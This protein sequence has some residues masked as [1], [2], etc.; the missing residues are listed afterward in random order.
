VAWGSPGAVE[1]DL[2][3][4]QGVLVARP[5]C[6]SQGAAQQFAMEG[7]QEGPCNLLAGPQSREVL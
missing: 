3:V 7:V 2:N 4:P 6:V 1:G 5:W